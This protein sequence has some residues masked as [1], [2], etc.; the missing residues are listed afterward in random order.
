MDQR[1]C[2]V[3]ID[4]PNKPSIEVTDLKD[5]VALVRHYSTDVRA[6]PTV[7]SSSVDDSRL[8]RLWQKLRMR[9]AKSDV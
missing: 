8:R 1:I 4:I 2:S 3:S 9:I 6:S 5:V 7:Y